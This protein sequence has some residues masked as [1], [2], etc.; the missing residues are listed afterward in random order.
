MI[1]V[2]VRNIEQV[3][4]QLLGQFTPSQVLELPNLFEM[5]KTCVDDEG[6]TSFL[7]ARFVVSDG[8]DCYFEIIVDTET[9]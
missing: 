8:G 7:A 2:Y 5:F 6:P 9:E 1:D 4:G 3:K